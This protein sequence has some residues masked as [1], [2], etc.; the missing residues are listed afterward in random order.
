[1]ANIEMTRTSQTKNQ[2][3]EKAAFKKRVTSFL[4]LMPPG[5][6]IAGSV[7]EVIGE[8]LTISISALFS[9]AFAM[10]L[11]LRVPALRRLE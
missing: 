5:A 2:S 6:L 3:A 10:F 4:R 8:P 11:W 1:M 9:L 7:A